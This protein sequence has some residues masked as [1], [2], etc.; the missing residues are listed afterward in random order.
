MTMTVRLSPREL[1]ER[2]RGLVR[3][4]FTLIGFGALI[5]VVLT[6]VLAS[7]PLVLAGDTVLATVWIIV[8]AIVT[9]ALAAV[10]RDVLR[11]VA[12]EAEIPD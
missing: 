10:L 6:L 5:V 9:S 7:L 3:V 2:R 11:E 1:A 12:Q 4:A 8:V